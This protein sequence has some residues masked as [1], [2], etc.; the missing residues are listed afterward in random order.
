ME[1]KE[2]DLIGMAVEEVNSLYQFSEKTR[3][4]TVLG[5]GQTSEPVEASMITP[6]GKK[7]YMLTHMRSIR[8]I[9]DE[10]VGASSI[11]TDIT[12]LKKQQE[13]M[14]KQD[15]LA[16]VGQMAAGIVHEIRNPLTSI[17]VSA[18]CY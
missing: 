10:I 2:E 17:K 16:A 1:A 5:G 7:K 14:L 12:E 3:L 8:N 13:V 11:V 9:Y 18:N 15:Q 6:S 4:P